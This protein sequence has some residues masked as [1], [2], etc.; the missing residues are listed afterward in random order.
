MFLVAKLLYDYYYPCVC[1]S[2]CQIQGETRFSRPLIKIEV[3]FLL[4]I[5]IIYRCCHL[6]FSISFSRFFRAFPQY[7]YKDEGQ[8]A[9]LRR[10]DPHDNLFLILVATGLQQISPPATGLQQIFSP[11]TGLQPISPPAT[12]LQQISLSATELLEI[13]LDDNDSLQIILLAATRL[14]QIWLAASSFQ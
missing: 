2:V 14:Q 6:C 4:C 3:L 9:Q 5:Y 10:N 1:P 12:G 8:P 11:A 13:T 7:R